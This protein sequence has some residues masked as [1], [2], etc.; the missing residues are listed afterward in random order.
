MSA[1]FPT[2]AML[3]VGTAAL[4]SAASQSQ[5]SR[6]CVR[7][8]GKGSGCVALLF[9]C[10]AFKN[11]YFSSSLDKRSSNGLQ[12]RP[13]PKPLRLICR[14]LEAPIC[15]FK[16]CHVVLKDRGELLRLKKNTT[17]ACMSSCY[18]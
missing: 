6:A 9:G 15:H 13:Q 11:C 10:L 1:R 12:V 4:G 18:C 7:K 2:A 16:K 17:G 3:M 8:W 5:G 14:T